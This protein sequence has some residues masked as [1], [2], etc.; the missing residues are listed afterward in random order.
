MPISCP[1]HTT[2]DAPATVRFRSRT[3]LLATLCVALSTAASVASSQTFYPAPAEESPEHWQA[4]GQAELQRALARTPITARAK[5]VILFVGDG[6]GISTVTAARIFDAQMRGSAGEENLLAFENFP[7]VG[8]SKTYNTNQQTADSAGTMTAMMSGIKT[9]AGVIG[10]NQY[11]DRADCQSSQGTE[12]PSLMQ[13]AAARGLATGIVTTTRITHATPAAT[14]AHTPERDWESDANMSADAIAAGC[15][16]IAAQLLAFDFGAGINVAMGG[17]L[18][19]FVPATETEPLTGQAGQRLDG[20]NLTREWLQKY[21]DSAFIWNREQLADL[22]ISNTRHVLGLFN[23]SQMS[24]SHDRAGDEASEP[25][26]PT[27]TETAIRLLQQQGQEDGFFLMV[28]SG[29]IDHAHHAGN[30][31]RALQDTREFAAAIQSAMA[32]TSDEDTLIIVTADHSHTLTIGGYAT[33]GNPILGAVVGNDSHGHPQT[34]LSVADDNMPYTTLGYRDGLGF[35][36]DA[37]GDRRYLMP[38]ASG[39]HDLREVDTTHP[40]FHQEALVPLESEG[41]AGEDVAIYAR[42]PWAHLIHSTHE[43]HYIY[44]VMRHALGW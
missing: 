10:V 25:D 19:A 6:M 27:M 32:L 37:G 34:G 31:Y 35:A 13:D 3:A 28:E 7:Y 33:R 21:P 40:D 44:H 24:Y 12:V 1:H 18:A 29:R 36:E 11:A 16:D 42:G 23:R 8:L 5:N 30:A 14:Y 43:Q 4:L 17:G 41:H 22:D 2:S 39:R 15:R 38:I 20:R 26:L 9:R